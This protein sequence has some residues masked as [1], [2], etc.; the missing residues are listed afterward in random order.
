MYVFLCPFNK[1]SGI[2]QSGQLNYSNFEYLNIPDKEL[3]L[4]DIIEQ[5]FL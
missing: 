2:I 3:N 1:E 4:T 5:Q